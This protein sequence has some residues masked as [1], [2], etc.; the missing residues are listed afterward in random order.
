MGSWMPGSAV[1]YD[2]DGFNVTMR[3]IMVAPLTVRCCEMDRRGG[4]ARPENLRP[5]GLAQVLFLCS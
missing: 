5:A 2:N 4:T 1:V 3:L